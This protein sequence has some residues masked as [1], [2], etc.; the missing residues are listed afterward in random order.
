VAL[1]ARLTRHLSVV[2]FAGDGEIDRVKRGEHIEVEE[3]GHLSA[4]S[5]GWLQNRA[6]SASIGP[7]GYRQIA[8]RNRPSE[9]MVQPWRINKPKDN[10]SIGGRSRGARNKIG[11]EFSRILSEAGSDVAKRIVE[12][13]RDKG[14]SDQL[15]GCR[16]IGH[17]LNTPPR[18]TLVRFYLPRIQSAKDVPREGLIDLRKRHPDILTS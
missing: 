14:H 17:R 3:A 10:F 7:K 9:E 13:A 16:F 5:R 6:Y 4:R 2:A 11:V 8:K 12:I 15:L 18:G 1:T